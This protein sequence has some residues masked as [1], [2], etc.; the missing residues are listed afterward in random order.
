M[1]SSIWRY[2][3]FSALTGTFGG[4]IETSSLLSYR[5]YIE[6]KTGEDENDRLYLEAHSKDFDAM[7]KLFGAKRMR[8]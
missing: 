1:A 3:L 7:K 6:I 2:N 4:Q 5:W 8:Q